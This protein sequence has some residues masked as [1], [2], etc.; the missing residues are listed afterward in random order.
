MVSQH[1][2]IDNIIHH[3]SEMMKQQGSVKVRSRFGQGSVKVQGTSRLFCPA[4]FSGI[5]RE[6]RFGTDIVRLVTEL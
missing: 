4:Y 5:H 6:P 3:C 2:W 1:C